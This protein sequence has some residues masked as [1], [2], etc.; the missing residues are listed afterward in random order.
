[1]VSLTITYILP[2]IL[3][4]PKTP[5]YILPLLFSASFVY[6]LTPQNFKAVPFSISFSQQYCMGCH[7]C[8][9]VDI[10]IFLLDSSA[11]IYKPQ[12]AYPY[13]VSASVSHS[14]TPPLESFSCSWLHLSLSSAYKSHLLKLNC[15][16][17]QSPILDSL[18]PQSI[19][20]SL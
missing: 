8:F 7:L 14:L 12:C 10:I 19:N 3:T 16:L 1:M 5:L 6:F 17:L 4:T 18:L 20:T 15:P 13:L 11:C 2:S 9:L